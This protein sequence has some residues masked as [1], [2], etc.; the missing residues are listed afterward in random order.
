MASK[1]KTMSDE[2]LAV[3]LDQLN[4]QAVGHMSDEVSATQDDNLE[5]YLGMPYGDEEEGRS[6]AISMD[7]A[8]VV[9]WAIPDILEPFISGDRVVEFKGSSKSE[10]DY[11]ER[12]TDLINH[13]FWNENDGVLFLHDVVKTGSIQKICFS[14]TV[15]QEE[16][17]EIRETMTGL[18][19]AHLAELQADQSIALE[20][21]TAEPL[22]QQLVD[23]EALAAFS[24]GQV[25]TVTIVRIKK[26]GFNRLMALPPEQ[27]KFSDHT[28]ELVDIDY[29]CHETPDMTRSGLLAMGFPEEKVRLVTTENQGVQD[30]RED[31]RFHDESKR[32]S[33]V[34]QRAKERFTLIEEYPLLDTNED[35]RA[36]RL[37]VFRVGKVILDRKEVECHPFDAWSPDR[38][39]HRLVGLGIADKVKQTAYIK[40]HL[41]RQL[42]DNVYLANNPRIEV[43][44]G[45]MGEDT[46]GDLLTYRVGGLIRTKGNG[47]MLR[48]IE[49]PDRSG[50]ALQAILYM[51][52][53]REQ[54]SGVTKNGLAIQ[55]EAIDPKSATESRRQDRNEQTRKR[56]MCRMLAHT[57]LVPVF[58]KMLKNCVRYQDAAKEIELRGEWVMIDPRSWNAN[59]KAKVAV[60]LGH[61]NRD[62]TMQGA[63]VVGQAQQLGAEA[64]IVKPKHLYNT[65]RKL[66]EAAGIGFPEDFFLDPDSEEGQQFAQERAQSQGQDPKMMEAQGK[67]QIKQLETQLKAQETQFKSQLAQQQAETDFRIAQ[68]EAQMEFALGQMKI[69]AETQISQEQMAAEMHLAQW[70]AEQN[71]D[72][73]REQVRRMP[74][75]KPNGTSSGVRFGGK[76]G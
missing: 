4:R 42:L 35:G 23:P 73:K 19:V 50:T 45:A 17:D 34:T 53:V 1:K 24:D 49:I 75:A 14:K 6:Q 60:G 56:L 76:V 22:N 51:D 7:V 18:S 40:T 68:M 43:P 27:V 5:R 3:K 30:N 21:V 65:A 69:R 10:A 58:K 61:A 64:G 62:E 55:S 32:D 59:L 9:D 29:I 74:A 72:I 71:V 2:E 8:E 66:V 33:D 15:W 25:Y 52:G 12:A 39:P 48:P 67:L 37:Q 41:T 46:I 16:E 63:T 26:R 38:I 20:D 11:A 13:E 57:F 54:Q 44:D 28:S 36:E 47:Q 31:V 70:Q